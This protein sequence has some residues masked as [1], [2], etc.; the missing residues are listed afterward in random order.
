[1]TDTVVL[2]CWSSIFLFLCCILITTWT[3][4]SENYDLL[5]LH[6]LDVL[7]QRPDSNQWHLEQ[8][9]RTGILQNTQVHHKYFN[10][11]SVYALKLIARSKSEGFSIVTLRTEEPVVLLGFRLRWVAQQQ[12]AAEAQ[13]VVLCCVVSVVGLGAAL[14]PAVVLTH[15][16]VVLCCRSAQSRPDA[17]VSSLRSTQTRDLLMLCCASQCSSAHVYVCTC[18]SASLSRKQHNTVTE[19]KWNLDLW[20]FESH[21]CLAW[22]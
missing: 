4:E 3:K 14:L 18:V 8:T 13:R 10:K 9:P 17:F 15:S 1:M 12:V 21:H 20:L 6:H 19:K 22:S 16:R 5:F 2:C 7:N 11:L